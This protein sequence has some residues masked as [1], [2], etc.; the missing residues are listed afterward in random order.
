MRLPELHGTRGPVDLKRGV[1]CV[2]LIRRQ[3]SATAGKSGYNGAVFDNGFRTQA[4]RRRH[5]ARRL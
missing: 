1:R 3:G 2:E 4:E 5:A